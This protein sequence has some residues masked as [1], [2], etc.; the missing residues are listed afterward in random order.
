MVRKGDVVTMW[1][2][3]GPNGL[4]PYHASNRNVA[5]QHLKCLN[6]STAG[7]HYGGTHRSGP[8]VFFYNES[9]IFGML[10]WRALY[11]WFGR[12][13]IRRVVAEHGFRVVKRR[14]LVAWV[15]DKQVAIVPLD[16]PS[17]TN[18]VTT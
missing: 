8:D 7:G 15:S 10:S 14:G 2:L 16:G 11:R 12:Q 3:E 9:A 1:R 18:E 5:A 4:G 13:A 6:Y 17:T